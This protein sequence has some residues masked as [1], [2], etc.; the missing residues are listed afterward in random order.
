MTEQVVQTVSNAAR[1][2]G[3]V[4]RFS[5]SFVTASPEAGV[6]ENA[7][8]RIWLPAKNATLTEEINEAYDEDAEREDEAFFR[9]TKAYYRR[10]F[11]KED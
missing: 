2:N 10:R 6:R 8:T 11:S 3:K 7:F 9:S 1:V 5:L 4:D